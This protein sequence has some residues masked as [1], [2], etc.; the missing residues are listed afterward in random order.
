M[1][2]SK[3]A[4]Q[5]LLNN[6]GMFHA[7]DMEEELA[8][9]ESSEEIEPELQPEEMLESDE[10]E[11][12]LDGEEVAAINPN[13]RSFELSPEVKQLAKQLKPEISEQE[14]QEVSS[15]MKAPIEMRKEAL[16]RIKQKYLGQ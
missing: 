10:D 8:P 5:K 7:S 9:D 11:Q 4:L 14:D 13:A 6:P 2:L 15:D 1:A 3:E 12:E 16:K